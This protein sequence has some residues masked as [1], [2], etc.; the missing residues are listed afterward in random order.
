MPYRRRNSGVRRKR[1]GR[2]STYLPVTAG[3]TVRAQGMRNRLYRRSLLNYNIAPHYFKR[4]TQ[5][6]YSESAGATISGMNNAAAAATY[7]TIQFRLSDVPDYSEFTSMYDQY[8]ITKVVLRFI[9]G[10]NYA[11]I[12]NAA[13]IGAIAGARLCTIIDHDDGTVPTIN[14]MRQYTSCKMTNYGV[15]HKRVVTPS[16]LGM[17]FETAIATAYTPMFKQWVS[18]TD[19]DTP[20]YGVKVAIIS[21][22]PAS[23]ANSITYSIEAKYYIKCKNVK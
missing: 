3:S 23:V 13:P 20:H 7:Q 1:L 16:V 9:P 12:T 17:R 5:N 18:T 4:W 22:D 15:E 11:D 10:R 21:N 19:P 8:C 14:Q 2:R 6:V